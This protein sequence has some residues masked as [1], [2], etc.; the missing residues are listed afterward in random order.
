M[1]LLDT[2]KLS[3]AFKKLIGKAQTDNL[4]ESFNEAGFSA[5][6]IFASQLP[7]LEIPRPPLTANLYD[8]T[9]VSGFPA[10]EFLRCPLTLDP[11]SNGHGY[12]ASLPAAYQTGSS[13]PLKGTDPFTNSKALK[14]SSGKLQSIPPLF[15]LTYE[16]K[17][18][19]GGTEVKGSGTIIA[20]GDSRNWVFD[21]FNG[22]LFQ[23]DLVG[24]VPSYIEICVYV[25]PMASSGGSSGSTSTPYPYSGSG[26]TG[27]T[28]VVKVGGSLLLADKSST[29]PYS[30]V[31]GVL[32]NTVASGGL[33]LVQPYGY[34]PAGIL[35]ASSFVEGILPAVETRIW[36]ST[37]GLL[38][39]TPPDELTGHWQ[40]PIGIWDGTTLNL[41][42][43][44][45]GA[46]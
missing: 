7:A 8:L 44:F 25:G 9:Y 12:Y 27:G 16:A 33:A 41:Q 40:V 38:S 28:L 29:Y 32:L 31:L 17:L 36:L 22:I 23:Q 2:S 10:V 46:A 34:V 13:N 19:T 26:L 42:I 24:G 43:G 37:A 1:P 3:I 4:K 35:T 11:S 20:P 21:Y 45:L 14:S 39:V 18:Y 5:P 6:S 15:G 30:C